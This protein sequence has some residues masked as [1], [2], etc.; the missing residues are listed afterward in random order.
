LVLVRVRTSYRVRHQAT[1]TT[2][3]L[4]LNCYLKHLILL[5]KTRLGR[6]QLEI[7]GLTQN[8]YRMS[9]ITKKISIGVAVVVLSALILWLASHAVRAESF[10]STTPVQ[11]ENN[12][13]QLTRIEEKV[14]W[15]IEMEIKGNK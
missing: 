14:D 3:L 15:L 10:M 11:I 1:W 12:E 2:G 4:P 5:A 7:Q 9:E 8:S 6:E 13:K